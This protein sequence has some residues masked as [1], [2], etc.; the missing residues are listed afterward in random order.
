MTALN[1]DARRRPGLMLCA[2]DPQTSTK[3]D[4]RRAV[5]GVARGGSAGARY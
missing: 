2:H 1:R 4:G 3:E 5:E